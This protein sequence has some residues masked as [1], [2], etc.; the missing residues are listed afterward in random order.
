MLNI[1]S[2]YS[3]EKGA[4]RMS[5]RRVRIL[6]SALVLVLCAVG[7][8]H[9]E[10]SGRIFQLAASINSSNQLEYGVY[11]TDYRICSVR[12]II[13]RLDY[14]ARSPQE[15]V[16]I[17]S[18]DKAVAQS[19]NLATQISNANYSY[20]NSKDTIVPEYINLQGYGEP[21]EYY[22]VAYGFS[23]NGKQ[24]AVCRVDLNTKNPLP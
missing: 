15:Y 17:W 12:V 21:Y 23:K 7:T 11:W 1:H 3:K 6:V 19:D 13:T 24:L 4:L 2:C 5:G 16:G 8:V 22:V 14:A 18:W 9:A 10:K 20:S